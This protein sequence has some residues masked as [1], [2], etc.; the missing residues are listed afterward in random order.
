MRFLIYDFKKGRLVDVPKIKR[1]SQVEY[2]KKEGIPNFL[3]NPNKEKIERD[4]N[5]E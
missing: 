5:D 3:G 4:K 2:R 1:E